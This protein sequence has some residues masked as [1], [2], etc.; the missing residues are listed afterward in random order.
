[1]GRENPSRPLFSSLNILVHNKRTLSL[2]AP[3]C[4]HSL[5]IDWRRFKIR[6]IT[7][8]LV[9]VGE[10]LG[11]KVELFFL[12]RAQ[13]VQGRRLRSAPFFFH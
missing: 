12:F 6:A 1:M 10:K 3:Q 8:K 11:G 13:E 5:R 2:R 7:G 4:G 9:T